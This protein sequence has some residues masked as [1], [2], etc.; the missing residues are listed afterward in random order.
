M[1]YRRLGRTGLKV[2]TICLGT[3]TYGSQVSKDDATQIIQAALSAGI[4]FFD[5]ACTYA[6]GRSEEI[7]GEALKKER[8]SVIIATK[9]ASRTGP[10]PNDVGLSRKHILQEVEGSLHRLKTDY[11]DLYYVHRPDYDTP[12]EETLRTLDD[13]VRQGKVRYIGCSNFYAWYLCKALWV[14]DVRN[15][16]PFDCVQPPYS[17]LTRDMEHELVPLCESEGLGICVYNPL[18]G[19]LLTGKH[20]LERPPSEGTRF[21][22]QVAKGMGQRYREKYWSEANFEAVAN[23]KQIA[24]EHGHSLVQLGLAWVL[25]KRAITSAV[26]G[27]TSLKQLEENLGAVEMEPSKDEIQAIDNAYP[28]RP[29]GRSYGQ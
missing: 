23:F 3:L 29:T 4:N 14:S 9:V 6:E 7:L 24:R 27:A 2:S 17:L 20:E 15:L 12:L 26:T 1:Q 19:G 22:L 18:A 28:Y 5:T 8:H 21:A 11:I 25:N 10:G 16:A 13:L